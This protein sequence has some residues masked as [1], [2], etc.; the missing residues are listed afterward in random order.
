MV[1]SCAP[2]YSVWMFQSLARSLYTRYWVLPRIH[3]QYAK[4]PLQQAFQTV[5]SSGAWQ[6][7]G[8]EYS[9]GAGS[10][11]VA[12]QAY[13]DFV[14]DFIRTNNISSVI[15]VG[16]GDFF[17]GSRILDATDVT[18]TAVDIVPELIEHHRKTKAHLSRARFLHAD[19][20]KDALPA[21]DLC[22]VR[23]VLQHLSNAEISQALAN[24]R[25]FP[26]V[27]VSEDLP[28]Q[29]KSANRDKPH[30]PDVRRY[31]GSAVLVDQPPFS[32]NV[33]RFTD[34]ELSGDSVLRT[35]VID[36]R[37]QHLGATR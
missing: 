37:T 34:I 20:T 13:C 33:A 4:L 1:C 2:G 26:I 25:Q 36:R 35:S 8:S 24:L 12:A 32:E 27:L 3:R 30:G 9:S 28:K 11:G 15:D 31:Y 10:R 22:L 19:I 18:Y 21:A 7:D 17:V 14:I 6:Q 29:L 5:Y 16:C 23:Q